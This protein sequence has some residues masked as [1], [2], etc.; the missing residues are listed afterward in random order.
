MRPLIADSDCL[1]SGLTL[2]AEGN[3][4]QQ[5]LVEFRFRLG[6]LMQQI[7]RDLESDVDK[8]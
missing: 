4:G 7:V 8:P 3:S 2:R 6:Q 5:V 1:L